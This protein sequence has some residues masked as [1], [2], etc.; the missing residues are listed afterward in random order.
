M[1]AE[2]TT[3]GDRPSRRIDAAEH[4]RHVVERKRRNYIKAAAILLVV[5]LA[6]VIIGAGGTLYMVKRRMHRQPP[7]ADQI[8]KSILERMDSTLS[9]TPD[10]KVRL[11]QIVAEHMAEVE[12]VRRD[13]MA[14]IRQEFDVMNDAIDQV[15]GPERSE[16]WEA[17][18]R[19]RYGKFYRPP[20]E[21]HATPSRREH[22]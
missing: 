3:A 2:P 11:E 17:D 12:T 14:R 18:K 4:H 16:K 13:T 20:E 21:R 7:K 22:R 19:E 15:L 6:G 10:E 1:N 9:I 8:G 5:M